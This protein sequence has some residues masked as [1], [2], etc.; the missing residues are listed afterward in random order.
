[1]KT[2]VELDKILNDRVSGSTRIA[3]NV[4]RYILNRSRLGE[5]VMPMLKK[6]QTVRPEMVVLGNVSLFC[7]KQI[8]Q[9]KEPVK[10]LETA[11]NSLMSAA[12]NSASLAIQF[13]PNHAI[14]ATLSYSEQLNLLFKMA[15]QK[16]D[17]VYIFA[18][19]LVDEEKL[20]HNLLEKLG[21]KSSILDLG[22]VK[23]AIKRVDCVIVGSDSLSKKFFVNKRGTRMLARA[24]KIANVPVYVL[25]N[26]WKIL[27]MSTGSLLN[28]QH[29]GNFERIPNNIVDLFVMESGAFKP[30]DLE[31]WVEQIL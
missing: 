6:M 20:S 2:C 23:Y 31:S 15:K 13:I 28:I 29:L 22:S 26:R 30:K 16:I 12:K 10:V 9:G 5:D 24:S 27:Y 7:Q 1:M 4:I 21:L 17:F 18:K 14:V 3:L 8:K 19:G 25:S 11:E